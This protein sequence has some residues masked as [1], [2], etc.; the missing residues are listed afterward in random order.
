VGDGEWK[1]KIT[2]QGEATDIVWGVI[3]AQVT[4]DFRKFIHLMISGSLADLQYSPDFVL[5]DIKYKCMVHS[6]DAGS[7]M[8]I[9]REHGLVRFYVQ[10][11]SESQSGPTHIGKRVLMSVCSE[12][13]H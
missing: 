6:K 4:T 10:L 12:L 8:V 2:M 5:A 11:R 1:G 3:D 13:R 7:I 9:P